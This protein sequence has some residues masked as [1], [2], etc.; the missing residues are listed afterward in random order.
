[1]NIF[2]DVIESSFLYILLWK[3]QN[4]PQFILT[5]SDKSNERVTIFTPSEEA[6]CVSTDSYSLCPKCV[7]YIRMGYESEEENRQFSALD[8]KACNN[9]F[10]FQLQ[11][12][13]K[14]F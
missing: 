6:L 13:D 14:L 3:H 8:Y 1:M 11:V 9:L 12:T 10:I 2:I 4:N 5:N 7:G